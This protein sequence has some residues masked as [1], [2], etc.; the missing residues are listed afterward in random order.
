MQQKCKARIWNHYEGCRSRNVQHDRN[1][2]LIWSTSD[3]CSRLFLQ[4]HHFA[5]LK[6]V[7]DQIW[8]L[9]FIGE[10]LLIS[11]PGICMFVGSLFQEIV[12]QTLFVKLPRGC[13]QSNIG[14]VP[15]S[16]SKIA[17]FR[18]LHFGPEVV[19]ISVVDYNPANMSGYRKGQPIKRAC[20][21]LRSSKL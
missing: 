6:V 13:V 16:E 9:Q 21:S 7:V 15:F 12:D 2:N 1:N 19:L 11:I 20:L 5:Q 17:P 8:T 4:P 14:L 10:N 3:S 18:R